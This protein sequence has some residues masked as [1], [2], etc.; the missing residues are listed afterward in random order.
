M[1]TA[2]HGGLRVVKATAHVREILE[3]AHLF[4]LL[5]GERELERR[6]A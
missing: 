6:P 4:D 2:A 1:T 5:N 3:R